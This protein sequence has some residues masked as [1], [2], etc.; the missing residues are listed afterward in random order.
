MNPIIQH[1]LTNWKSSVANF[2]TVVIATGTYFA[3]VP[4]A[5]LQSAGVTQ[6]EIFIGTCIVGLAKVYI[7]LIQKDAQ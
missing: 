2:L 6:N 1:L 4:S 5:T 7:G 3:A